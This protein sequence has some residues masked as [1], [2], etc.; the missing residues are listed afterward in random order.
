MPEPPWATGTIGT[1][2]DEQLGDLL[3]QVEALLLV[4]DLTGLAEQLVDVGEA[5]A[6]LVGGARAEVE[7]EEVG[8]VGIVGAP[9]EQVER[10][11][12]GVAGVDEGGRLHRLDRRRDPDVGQLGLD[13]GGHDR[14][15]G[16]IRHARR[17]G[18]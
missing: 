7:V 14:R 10:Q 2:S 6:E 8:G 15:L 17:R 5:L 3:V 12:T 11:L 4:V 9:A 13:V 16:Q 1:C 18:S